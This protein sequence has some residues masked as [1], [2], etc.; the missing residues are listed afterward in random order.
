[1]E[2]VIYCILLVHILAGGVALLAAPVAMV[3]SK[4]G[5]AHRKWGKIYFWSMTGVF[6]TALVL[7]VFKWIPFLLMIAV[8]SYYWVVSGYR[9][10]YLK[11]LGYGKAPGA[12]DWVALSV[13]LV[14]NLV[15]TIWGIIQVANGSLGF[16]AY[17]AIGFG[18]GGLVIVSGNLRRFLNNKDKNAWLFEHIGSMLGSYIAAVTA[19]SSQVFSFMPGLL[20]WIWPSIV[21]APVIAYTIY[22][23]KKKINRNRKI[24][25]LVT[26]K[27]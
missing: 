21:G 8:F 16:Y 6:V 20:Q 19:F 17:L 10:L 5:K 26:V 13:A 27:S 3:V 1:M 4:G 18:F 14:F 22:K 7:S 11:K 12:P 25:D 9:W 15:F 23:Y 24:E 2:T